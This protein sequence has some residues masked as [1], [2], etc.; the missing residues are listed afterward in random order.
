[1][2]ITDLLNSGRLHRAAAERSPDR[3]CVKGTIHV[4]AARAEFC[5]WLYPMKELHGD[6]VRDWPAEA[7]AEY[8]AKYVP[9]H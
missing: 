4:S 9:S 2:T 7:R 8:D 3:V 5:N 6:N 1:M